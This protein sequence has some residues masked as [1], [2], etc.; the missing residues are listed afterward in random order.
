M[1]YASFPG[2]EY[3]ASDTTSGPVVCWAGF[4]PWAKITRV[5]R[6]ENH[7]QKKYAEKCTEKHAKEHGATH[8]E[9][10]VEKMVRE[11][12]GKLTQKQHADI[13]AE[14]HEEETHRKR[15]RKTRTKEHTENHEQKN[16]Q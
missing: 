12:H 3:R 4:M 14:K 6:T 7:T 2:R 15:T 11:T 10:K 8:T 5:K 1:P 13:C 9:K 16:T